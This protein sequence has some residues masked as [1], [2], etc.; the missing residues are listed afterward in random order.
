MAE[1]DARFFVYILAAGITAGTPVLLAS[2]GEIITQKSGVMNLG[3]EGMMLMGA[4]SGFMF[5]NLTGSKWLGLLGVVV[6]SAVLGLILGFMLVKLRA[7]QVAT[8]IAFLIFCTG[9][10]S[11]MGKPYLGTVSADT[12]SKFQ[13]ESLSN[14][15]LLQLLLQ[16]DAMVYIAIILAILTWFLIYRTK[17]GLYL[18]ATGDSPSSV[19][20]LGVNV[21]GIRIFAVVIGC[22]LIGL[23]GAYLSLAY[24]LSWIE[25]MTNGRGW[26]AL[27]LVNFAVWK[28]FNAIVGA[29]LFGIFYSLSLRLETIGVAISPYFLRM[30][31]YI[32]PILI[33]VI[34]N[35]ARKRKANVAPA[36][37][38]VPYIREGK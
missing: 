11:L 28:P 23:G 10:S 19:D 27:A 26:L 16:Q 24:S 38:G 31:P 6:I 22:V 15:P 30:I 35:W 21:Y 5:T 33:L 25:G 17:F 12:F 34:I 1:I 20:S 8:G 32:L 3:I 18:R 4:M 29:Y 14:F 2:L 36:T 37:L 9:L 7:N 13:F